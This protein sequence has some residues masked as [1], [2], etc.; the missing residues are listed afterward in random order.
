M[1]HLPLATRQLFSQK[2]TV[3][4]GCLCD[5]LKHINHPDAEALATSMLAEMVG[6]VSLAR[7]CPDPEQGLKMLEVSRQYLKKRA[8]IASASP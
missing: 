6:S 3:L 7:A 2:R 4:C 1:A 8:G 5:A